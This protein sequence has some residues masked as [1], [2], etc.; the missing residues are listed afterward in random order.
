[1]KD[2]RALKT[3]LNPGQFILAEDNKENIQKRHPIRP[4]PAF[5]DLSTDSVGAIGK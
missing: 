2:F 5:K 4:Q 3:R 1:M